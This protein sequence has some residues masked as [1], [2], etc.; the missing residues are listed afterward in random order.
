MKSV[1]QRGSVG[2]F[3]RALTILCVGAITLWR[4]QWTSDALTRLAA[5]SGE[6]LASAV[7]SPLAKSLAVAYFAWCERLAQVMISG[8]LHR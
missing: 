4:P 3:A 2:E 5:R 7:Q 1:S 6:L 8:F